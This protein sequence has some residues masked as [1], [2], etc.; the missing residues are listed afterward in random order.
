LGICKPRLPSLQLAESAFSVL[1]Q[2]VFRSPDWQG[3]LPLLHD[4]FH[5]RLVPNEWYPF[6][7]PGDYR[8]VVRLEL[9]V[10]KREW[11]SPAITSKDE[12]GHQVEAAAFTL[13]I[14]PR[15][16]AALNRRCGEFMS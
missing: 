3:R 4:A 9:P 2:V 16:E 5:Q 7:D 12:S 14:L 1:I 8:I 11:E 15:N 13:K 6:N 10:V